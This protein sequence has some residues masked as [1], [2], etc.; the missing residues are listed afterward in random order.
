M[1]SP[2]LSGKPNKIF[3]KGLPEELA[4]ALSF[5]YIHLKLSYEQSKEGS[6]TRAGSP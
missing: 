2:Q 5:S 4:Q 1:M 6:A 3:K